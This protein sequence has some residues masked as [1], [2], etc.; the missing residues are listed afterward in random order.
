MRGYPI[1][2]FMF[3]EVREPEVKKSF[4]R[5]FHSLNVLRALRRKQSG[6]RHQGHG[7]FFASSMASSD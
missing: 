6:L 7:D 2:T 3:W 1:N 4:L 5:F